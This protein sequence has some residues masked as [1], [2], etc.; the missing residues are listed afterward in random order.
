MHVYRRDC[1]AFSVSDPDTSHEIIL[2]SAGSKVTSA[3]L[4]RLADPIPPAPPPGAQNFAVN[5]AEA[6]IVE[7]LSNDD[8]SSTQLGDHLEKLD[9]FFTIVFTLELL[10]NAYANWFQ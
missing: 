9:T 6:Q 1:R 8:G 2:I 3:S 5:A 4:A 7:A 10:I